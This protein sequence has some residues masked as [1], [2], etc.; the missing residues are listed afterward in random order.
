MVEIIFWTAKLKSHLC[1]TLCLREMKI[2]FCKVSGHLKKLQDIL[3]CQICPIHF[4]ILHWQLKSSGKS[5]THCSCCVRRK[6]LKKVHVRRFLTQLV[7]I[8]F[9]Q[10]LLVQY[11]VQIKQTLYLNLNLSS[12][13]CIQTLITLLFKRVVF[14]HGIETIKKIREE[15]L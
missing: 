7:I 4:S 15:W 3:I 11:S 14:L 5:S 6:S 8:D 2:S 10:E 1:S 9:S 12:A 13:R